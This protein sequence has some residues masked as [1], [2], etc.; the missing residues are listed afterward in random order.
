MLF[1]SPI[2]SKNRSNIYCLLSID[3]HTH[4][5]VLL[6][7]FL[8][9]YAT[10]LC[11]MQKKQIIIDTRSNFPAAASNQNFHWII[12]GN[13]CCPTYIRQGLF[14]FFIMFYNATLSFF[15]F[16]RN[17][18]M[19]ILHL[20]FFSDCDLWLKWAPTTNFKIVVLKIEYLSCYLAIT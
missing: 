14:H 13:A 1:I 2:R 19:P 3:I 17:L 20:L 6:L 15:F 7:P 12:N 11:Q 16:C 9:M 18:P 10:S 5:C 4:A 8:G